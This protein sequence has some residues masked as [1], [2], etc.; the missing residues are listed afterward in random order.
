MSRL[1]ASPPTRNAGWTR[2]EAFRPLLTDYARMRH[3]AE[4]PEPQTSLLSP[5]LRHRLVREEEIVQAALETA[6][7]PEVE[8]FVEEVCWRTYWKGWLEQHPRVWVDYRLALDQLPDR[9]STELR[10]RYDRALAGETGLECFDHWVEELK[11]THYLHNHVRMWFASIWIFTF[12]LPWQLGAEFFRRHLLDADPASNTLSWR[13]VAGLHTRGKHY[14]ARASN[15]SRY[16]GGRFEPVGQLNEGAEPVAPDAAYTPG[17]LSLAASLDTAEWPSLSDS[18][19]GLLVTGDDLSPE[20]GE[21][22]RLPLVSIAVF[23][24]DDLDL[25]EG[26]APAVRAWRSRALD[27]AAERAAQH[28]RGNL[29][30]IR[31]AADLNVRAPAAPQVSTP[32][33]PRVYTGQV[34]QWVGGVVAWAR[35]EH[36]KVV[37]LYQP[38]V[39]F[40]RDH[41]PHLR[42]ELG[43]HGIGLL[44]HRRRWDDLHWPHAQRGFFSFRRD[45][46]ERLQEAGLNPSVP[47]ASRSA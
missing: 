13:W 14:L 19:A 38:Q 44:E 12:G 22:A 4:T 20:S 17:S 27:D 39:G 15:I 8:K 5:Y 2:W 28:W 10:E 42:R 9:L 37:R 1:S 45:L 35:R 41:L 36:L 30:P 7:W 31:E 32:T 11:S 23:A 18:P 29:F 46:R 26:S 24:A 34:D 21:L 3:D 40:Y 33:E 16:T 47:R 6:P 43:R 25:A